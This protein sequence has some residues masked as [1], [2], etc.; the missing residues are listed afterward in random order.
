[1][2]NFERHVGNVGAARGARFFRSEDEPA[3]VMFEFV[4]D[5]ATMIGPRP[6]TQ[7]DQ[8]KHPDAWAAYLRDADLNPLDRDAD[9]AAGGSLP[10]EPRKPKTKKVADEPADDHSEGG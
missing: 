9:G 6:A 2:T 10:K 3:Q 7:A 1:M 4:V 8:A 5:P